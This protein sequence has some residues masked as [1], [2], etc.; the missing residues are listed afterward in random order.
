MTEL[1]EY[2]ATGR[3]KR[4]V[5]R[6]ILRPGDGKLKINRRGFDSYFPSEALRAEI[7]RP[8]QHRAG[9]KFDIPVNAGVAGCTARRV[10]P[11]WASPGR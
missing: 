8:C 10:Q 5:A 9:G 6:V 11:S 7:Q 2:R 4:S 3:R 1:A